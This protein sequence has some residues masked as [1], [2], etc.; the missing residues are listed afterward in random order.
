SSGDLADALKIG[1]GTLKRSP[2][3]NARLVPAFETLQSFATD[4]LVNLGVKD[5]TS[6]AQI[7]GPTVAF[8]T[9]AQTVC[10]YVSLFFR[11][12]SSLLSVG[13]NHGTTQRFI[14]IAMPSGPNNE[15]TPASA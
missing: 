4:P 1:V 7:L 15:G 13:D 10:N 5:L 11:N 3:F 9:P 8:L 12:T 14:I 2:A 6:T